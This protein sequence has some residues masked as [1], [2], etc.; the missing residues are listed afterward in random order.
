METAL[1]VAVFAVLILG[2]IYF[3]IKNDDNNDDDPMFV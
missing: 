1:I 3:L 2:V